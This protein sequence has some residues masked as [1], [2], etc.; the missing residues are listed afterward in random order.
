MVL[1]CCPLA[2]RVVALGTALTFVAFT[3]PARGERVPREVL[4]AEDLR[5]PVDARVRVGNTHQS[6]RSAGLVRRGWC[7]HKTQ[8]AQNSNLILPHSNTLSLRCEKS[9]E[10][11]PCY[12]LT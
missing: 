1:P 10:R 5:H 3:T 9:E 4:G 11:T 7:L 8:K 2:L 12:A 6:M